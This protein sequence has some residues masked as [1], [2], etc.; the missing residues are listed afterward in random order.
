[1]DNEKG[2]NSLVHRSVRKRFP[3]KM[4][5]PILAISLVSVGSYA[6]SVTVSPTTYQDEKG[7]YFN[8]I[9]GFTALSNGF[10]VVQADSSATSLPALWSNAGTVQ[11]S[12]TAGQW[13]YSF[14]L[15]LNAAATHGTTYT[16]TASWDTGSGYNTLGS[17][18][19]VTT[20]GTITAGQTMTFLIDTGVTSF[21][22]PTGIT[23]TVA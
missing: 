3:L 23:I 21:S 14:T 7:I 13:Y 15:T 22:A 4:L 12:M 17:P 1:M 10:W 20:L 18:L 16:V 6:S 9:G 19:T 2:S 11:T 8:V 5:L